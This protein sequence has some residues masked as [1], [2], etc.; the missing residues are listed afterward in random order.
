MKAEA[1]IISLS[2]FCILTVIIKQ[3]CEKKA[4]SCYATGLSPIVLWKL[5]VFS[6]FLK[7]IC[8]SFQCT[9]EYGN[10]IRSN[11]TKRHPYSSPSYLGTIKITS[12]QYHI[13][14]I[15]GPYAL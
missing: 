14:S 9:K 8:Y 6:L 12:N 11:G 15:L 10:S 13:T 3:K 1:I 4:T 7:Q 2:L 5:T